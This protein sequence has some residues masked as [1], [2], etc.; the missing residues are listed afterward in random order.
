MI[1]GDPAPLS[2]ID[3][4]TLFRNLFRQAGTVMLLIDFDTGHIVGANP[5]AVRFYGYPA[6]ELQGMHIS[7]INILPPE[8]ILQRMEEA[9]ARQRG[10]FVFRHRLASGEL[11][12]VAVY[13]GP[14]VV[15][16]RTFLYS[17]VHDITEEVRLRRERE[18]LAKRLRLAMDVGRVVAWEL[19]EDGRM[20]VTWPKDSVYPLA[21]RGNPLGLEE[22]VEWFAAPSQAAF[23][24][25]VQDCLLYGHPLNLELRDCDGRWVHVAGLR[26][27]D[28][29]GIRAVGVAHDI[30]AIKTQAETER[31]RRKE[32]ESAARAKDE[33]LRFLSHELRTPLSGLVGL[34]RM[35]CDGAGETCDGRLL[36]ARE[37]AES[38]LRLL[39]DA[40]D[41]CRLDVGQMPLVDEAFSPLVLFESQVMLFGP[42]AEAKGVDLRLVCGLPSS[43]LVAAPKARLEQILSNLLSNAV[44]FTD[45]GEIV[46]TCVL[47]GTEDGEALAFTVQDTGCGIPPELQ[48]RLFEPYAQGILETKLARGSGLGLSIVRALVQRMGGTITVESEV[49]GG[50]T[51]RV[52][53][54]VRPVAQVES[55]LQESPQPR[56]EETSCVGSDSWHIL[57]AEDDPV[58]QMVARALL[59]RLG[60]RVEV[61]SNGAEAVAAVTRQRFHVALLDVSMPQLDGL[62]A[63]RRIRQI[64]P[65]LP[66]VAVSAFTS[67]DDQQRFAAVMDFVLAKPLSCD[68][69][70]QVFAQVASRPVA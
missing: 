1:W 66:L 49:N 14:V 48:A 33:F 13:S 50:T 4:A 41:L 21:Q 44:K 31:L 63:A 6:E 64:Q 39:S 56:F 51:F 23:A 59:E 30:T 55:D 47:H 2:P 26:M 32:A 38:M 16:A 11:R 29:D 53:V 8:I 9:R 40:L 58:N 22:V 57:V 19:H 34:L 20:Y 5:A 35:L 61:V 60:H 18:S 25:A 36:Q 54:P 15:R 68:A 27:E 42:Q 28:G 46:L 65:S 37:R 10:Y 62:E 45:H 70:V 24:A 52:A 43:R 69:L 3:E 12:D 17:V 7:R 67:A